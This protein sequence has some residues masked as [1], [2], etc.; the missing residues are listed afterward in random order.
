[1]EATWLGRLLEVVPLAGA[2]LVAGYAGAVPSEAESRS[3]A[4]AG[5]R[6]AVRFLGHA[7]FL[8]QW[9]PEGG[10]APVRVVTDPYP[11]DMG[12]GPLQVSADLVV[13]SHDHFDHCAS[14]AVGGRPE[15]IIGTSGKGKD[16]VACDREV[17]GL[18]VK[19]FPTYH[20]PGRGGERGKNMAFL[21]QAGDFRFL[22]LGDLGHVLSPDQAQDIG[23]VD[24]LF[25]PV[26]GHYTIDASQAWQVV[27]ALRPKVAVPMHY[28]T[29]A[30]RD[31]PLAPVDEFLRARP[32]VP[33]RHMAEAEV[34]PGGLPQALE[35]WHLVGPQG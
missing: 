15:T 9:Q 23:P 24:V 10:A 26:G 6:V 4:G 35:V 32:S 1:M 11:A 5:G 33:V 20:D 30:I 13:A 16:W 31:W 7:C 28:L 17:K 14:G 22:H 8:L 12:Y 21:V 2:L 3:G 34:A 27:G 25:V 19:G 29:P 18:R